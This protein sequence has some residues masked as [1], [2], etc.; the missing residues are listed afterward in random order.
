MEPRIE[1][2]DW[3]LPPPRSPTDTNVSVSRS[4]GTEGLRGA[5]HDRNF[6]ASEQLHQVTRVRVAVGHGYVALDDRHALD[7]HLG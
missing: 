3:T 4:S 5:R 2:S 6:A 1:R 7:A